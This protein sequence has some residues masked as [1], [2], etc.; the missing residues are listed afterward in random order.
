MTTKVLVERVN[1]FRFFGDR[2]ITIAPADVYAAADDA[3]RELCSECE[4]L[5]REIRIALVAN[6]ETYS[7]SVKTV[8]SVAQAVG[9]EAVLTIGSHDFQTGDVVWVA[10]VGGDCNGKKTLTRINSTSVSLDGTSDVP[11]YSGSLGT[12]EHYLSSVV[13]PR[14][15]RG[16]IVNSAGAISKIIKRDGEEIQVNKTN[17]TTDAA[18]PLYFTMRYSET[19][20]AILQPTPD[21]TYTFVFNAYCKPFEAQRPSS[22]VNPA[23]SSDYDSALYWGTLAHVIEQFK[24]EPGADKYVVEAIQMYEAY[25]QKA[26]DIRAKRNYSAGSDNFEDLKF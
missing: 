2:K 19:A 23:L 18:K 21:T 14:G 1:S 26:M 3:Q 12:V 25:K 5:E 16:I 10:N 13:R 20:E 8:T 22:T 7:F 15:M 9:G 11:N 6:Q 17:L 24:R 4:L